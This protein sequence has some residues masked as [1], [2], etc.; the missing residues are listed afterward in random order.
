MW[1]LRPKTFGATLGPKPWILP[2]DMAWDPIS[3]TLKV[4]C[5]SQDLGS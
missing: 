5:E 2:R 1:E 4:A 3:G